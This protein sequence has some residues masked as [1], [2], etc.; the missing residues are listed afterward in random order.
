M[1]RGSLG[2]DIALFRGNGN[3]LRKD[4]FEIGVRVFRYKSDGKLY[5]SIFDRKVR[6]M[7]FLQLHEKI[8]DRFDIFRVAFEPDMV[9]AGG[10]A[11]V[12]FFLNQF[13]VEILTAK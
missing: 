8:F 12:E 6:L 1:L 4:C 9:F 11:D 2:C 3:A 13:E 10:D 5:V 7:Q